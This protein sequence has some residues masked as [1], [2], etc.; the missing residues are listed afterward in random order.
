MAET[1]LALDIPETT[2]RTR[3]FRARGLLRES[4][5]REVDLEMQLAF[6]FAGVRCDRIVAKVLERIR[7]GT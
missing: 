6:G 5:A 1:A 7:D 3:F 2:V 4:I